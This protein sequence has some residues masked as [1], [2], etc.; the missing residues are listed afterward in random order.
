M[1]QRKT[2]K[3]PAG[4]DWGLLPSV[5]A[6]GALILL[7]LVFSLTGLDKFRL[8]KDAVAVFL[9]LILFPW[10]YFSR[11]LL[12]PAGR[13]IWEWLA[14]GMIGYAWLHL[15]LSS[16]AEVS[17]WATFY[18]TL[19]LLLYWVLYSLADLRF[20]QAVWAGLAAALAVNAVLTIAQSH[21]MF[22]GLVYAGSEGQVVSGRLT[23]AGLIGDANSGGF[24]FGLMTLLLIPLMVNA[25]RRLRRILVLG[26]LALN[27]AG[28][29]YTR[30]LTAAIALAVCLGLWLVF[31]HWWWLRHTRRVTRGLV[32]LWLVLLAGGAAAGAVAVRAGLAERLGDVLEQARKGDWTTVTAG[33]E[34]LYR[35]TWQ[36]IQERPLTGRGLNT[37]GR[38][39]FH[40]RTETETGRSVDLIQQPGAFREVHNDYLQVW[41]ELGLP[42][43]LGLLALFGVPLLLSWTAVRREPDRKAQYWYGTLAIAVV[44][45][46][47][48]ALAFFPLRLSL[49]GAACLLVLAGIRR[50]QT[51][52]EPL[53][54]GHPAARPVLGTVLLTAILAVAVFTAYGEVQR[55]RANNAIGSGAY[56]LEQAA[57]RGLPPVQ[58]RMVADQVR[59]RLAGY[60]LSPA[61]MPEL[62]NLRGTANL[63]AG[64]FD[65][66]VQAYAAAA[67]QIPSPEIYTNLAAAYVGRQDRASARRYLE[68]ALKY[69]HRYPKARQALRFLQDQPNP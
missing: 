37:F 36:M 17:F 3:P 4:I 31:H 5:L 48:S 35:L 13:A 58:Q 52:G 53:R 43:L 56:L 30:T 7:P 33:R 60:G 19:F 63:M 8:P 9:V 44:Y 50:H 46:L 21:G 55:W 51:R 49:T 15:L 26:L 65:E 16:A 2:R 20:Q 64:R 12:L 61:R 28:L 23:P 59:S 67:K 45:V 10:L 29:L 42:G 47:I 68:L 14:V 24:L 1:R 34:P 6:G 11:R 22:P 57:A 69:D 27:L 54:V 41:L 18:L 39:F 66:A 62:Y 38:E 32:V 25:N 40:Y